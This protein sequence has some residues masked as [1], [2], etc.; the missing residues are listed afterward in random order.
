MTLTERIQ[1]FFGKGGSGSGSKDAAK[2]RLLL[3]LQDDRL[4][5]TG[6]KKEALRK[7]IL[8]AIRKHLD[9]DADGFTMEF[10]SSSTDQ[11]EMRVT[12]PVQLGRGTVNLSK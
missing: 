11:K 7:D 8:A 6:E 12:A 1:L 5:L 10:M 3:V 9:I 2:S 4:G